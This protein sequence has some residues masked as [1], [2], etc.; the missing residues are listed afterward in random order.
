ML[1]R[2]LMI[3]PLFMNAW[4]GSWLICSVCIERMMQMSSAMPAMCGKWLEISWPEAPYFWKAADGPRALSTAP[5]K[6]QAK[7][8][9]H[10]ERLGKG[11]A[12]QPLEGRLVVEGLEL[13]GAAGHAQVNDPFGLDRKVRRVGHGRVP[14]PH[15]PSAV[16]GREQARIEQTGKRHAPQAVG[17]AAEEGTA[18]DAL[19]VRGAIDE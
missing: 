10:G 8:L 7:L 15:R 16:L 11:L 18:V 12:V 19:L 1:G 9:P 17:R 5:C 6:L 4:A 13:R 14:A 3:E 2:P